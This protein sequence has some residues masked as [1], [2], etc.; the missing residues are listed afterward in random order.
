MC[1]G[2]HSAGA[3]DGLSAS[4]HECC[5]DDG[6]GQHAPSDQN[7]HRHEDSCQHCGGPTLRVP[8]KVEA[9]IAE[10]I[11]QFVPAFGV[12]SSFLAEPHFDVRTT[13]RLALCDSSP[14]MPIGQQTCVLLV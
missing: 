2:A 6:S 5:P 9:S 14:P 13:R 12:T 3:E 7:G 10:P 11:L 1:V 8:E 4:R